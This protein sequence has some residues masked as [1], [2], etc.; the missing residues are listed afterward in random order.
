VN[1]ELSV[2]AA[3]WPEA[4]NR[5]DAKGYW[6]KAAQ[7]TSYFRETVYNN[8]GWGRSPRETVRWTRTRTRD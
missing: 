4:K 2:E 7:A 6:S 3:K 8:M 5:K 1:I